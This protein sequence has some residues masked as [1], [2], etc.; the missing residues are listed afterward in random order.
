MHPDPPQHDVSR[1]PILDGR[2]SLRLVKLRLALTLIAVAVLPIAAVSPLV[3]AVAEEA[4][5]T[6]HDRL[7]DQATTASIEIRR[8]LTLIRTAEQTLLADPLIIAA[9]SPNATSTDRQRASARLEQLGA[10]KGSPVLAASLVSADGAEAHFGTPIDLHALPPGVIVAGLAA[11]PGA[12]QDAGNAQVLVVESDGDAKAAR[13]IVTL[14]SVEGL[15][16][17]ASPPGRRCRAACCA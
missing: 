15:L 13:S 10:G 14:V 2:D 16:A 1:D 3:R 4:R 17:G 7:A 5:A 6:H 11:V 12:T 8:E 9:T